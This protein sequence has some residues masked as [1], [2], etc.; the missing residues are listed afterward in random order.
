MLVR[1]VWSGTRRTV[2]SGLAC[3]RHAPV[4]RRVVVIVVLAGLG[5]IPGLLLLRAAEAAP[6]A[7]L[8][9]V[10]LV[11]PSGHSLGGRWQAWANGS[12]VPTVSGR[13]VVRLTGCPG[14]P[15]VAGCVYTG[16]PRVIYL[17]SGLP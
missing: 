8:R 11:S 1:T 13:V 6:V 16:Q 15:K 17:K 10:R 9:A 14:Q 12:L 2:R 3:G 4:Q 5:L 7:A